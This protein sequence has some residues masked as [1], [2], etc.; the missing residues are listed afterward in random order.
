M[1]DTITIPSDA[2]PFVRTGAHDLIGDAAESIATA[3]DAVD[4]EDHPERYQ[5]P[6]AW[7]A[8]VCAAG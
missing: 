7:L 8:R 2:L 4:R 1:S 6:F 5:A 3:N